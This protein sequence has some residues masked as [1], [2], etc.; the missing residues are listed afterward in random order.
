[1]RNP[2]TAPQS[3]AQSAAILG[4]AWGYG[5]RD[6]RCAHGPAI[7][8]QQ[9]LL[10]WLESKGLRAHWQETYSLPVVDTP[11]SPV[12]LVARLCA[13]LAAGVRSAV[14][15]GRRFVVLGGDHSCA[16]GTWAGARDALAGRGPLGLIWID[17]HMDAHVP[18]TSPSGALHGMPVACLLGHGH[19][20]LLNLAGIRPPVLPEHL[21]LIGVRSH[22]PGETELLDRLG[23]RVFTMGEIDSRGLDTVVDEA[24]AIAQRNT[25]GF[26]LSIDLDGIDPRDAPGVGS[27]EPDGL[28]AVSLLPALRRIARCGLVGV[29]IAEYNPYLDRDHRTADLVRQL[30]A[31]TLD[32]G[33]KA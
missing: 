19:P 27:P 5:A 10:S 3:G 26:G 18:G 13:R 25:A 17:A 32:S 15:G 9:G 11:A 31:A 24:L 1:M 28:R 7:L 22:E 16:V 30:L 2:S 8:R 6:T 14:D 29:E 20:A 23:V 12:D 4:A 21:C 33:D